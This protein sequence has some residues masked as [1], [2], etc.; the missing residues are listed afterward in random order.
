M[1]FRF[2]NFIKE[3]RTDKGVLS[4]YAITIV[5]DDVRVYFDVKLK[6]DTRIESVSFF[7]YSKAIEYFNEK[8]A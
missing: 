8:S 7:E 1:D 3:I 4:M 5:S 6:K 2:E